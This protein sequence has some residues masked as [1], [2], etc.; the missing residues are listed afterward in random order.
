MMS[1]EYWNTKGI[2]PPKNDPLEQALEQEDQD[3]IK[4]GSRNPRRDL[5]QMRVNRQHQESINEKPINNDN[6]TNK[7]NTYKL[8]TTPSGYRTGYCD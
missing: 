5:Q 1:A 8:K 6:G 2:N 4:L 3:K 7:Y